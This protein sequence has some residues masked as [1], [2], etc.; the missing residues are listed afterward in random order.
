MCKKY[1]GGTLVG[2]KGEQEYAGRAFRPQCRSDTCV[3]R[4]GEKGCGGRAA[5]WSGEISARLMGSPQAEVVSWECPVSCRAEPP[6]ISPALLG[7][8]WERL[9]W[10][11]GRCAASAQMTRRQL[12]ELSV[13][14]AP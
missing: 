11:W 6:L 14:H 4:E 7:I 5:S 10:E 9:E 13:S 3:R 8:G 12:L 2:A 1:I